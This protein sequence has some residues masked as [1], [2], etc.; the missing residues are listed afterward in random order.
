[1]ERDPMKLL[2][3]SVDN[4]GSYDYFEI[5]FNNCGL[6]LLHGKT[7]SGKS[8]IPDVPCWILYGKTAKDGA[9]DDVRSWT[10][11]NESTKGTISVELTNGETINVTRIRGKANDND[12]FWFESGEAE[13]TPCRGKDV[14]E[15]QK[16]LEKRIG[17]SFETY[18]AGS[19]YHEFTPVGL[20]FS[21]SA[22]QR[23]QVFEGLASMVTATALAEK[24]SLGKK[25][26]KASIQ[27]LQS[28]H[29]KLEG[30]IKHIAENIKI[31]EEKAKT[32]EKDK[33]EKIEIL[34]NK[35]QEWLKRHSQ[36][37]DEMLN[38]LDNLNKEIVL[39]DHYDGQLI[40]LQDR[41][42]NIKQQKCP[43]CNGP[44]ASKD[45]DLFKE[46]LRA[47]EDLKRNNLQKL[48]EFTVLFETVKKEQATQSPFLGQLQQIESE[49][50][51]YDDMAE[52]AVG[53]IQGAILKQEKV[54]IELDTA[55]HKHTSLDT[56]Y[57]LS[58]EL[59]GALLAKVVKEIESS[60]NNTLETYFDAELRV[61]FSIEGADNLDVGITKNGH[62]CN[63]KQLSKG[64]RQMLKLAFVTSVMAASAN[65]AGV[66][67]S[68]LFFDESLDGL[69][70]NL[71]IKAF[72][73][74]EKLSVNHESIFLI[75]HAPEFQ[76]LFAN[77]YHV[78]MEGDYS[79]VEHES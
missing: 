18:I 34:E 19:Y 54:E 66:H 68:T 33:K 24:S 65:Q 51:Q 61:A 22:K 29:D 63:Y 56:L 35:D 37:L 12:L 30:T 46:R 32:F 3:C 25:G 23:R 43:A 13:S 64:Q 58:Y 38:E 57:E 36:Y 6:T 62:Y 55:R 44:K 28:E 2:S 8:T 50:N 7:G 74:F 15:T 73:L 14:T 47:A 52:K 78:T 17:I 20:F 40:E 5:D 10:I 4:F 70:V 69:D 67:F 75:D 59:R 77:K 39:K 45:L 72:A 41:I 48:S 16:L 1:M 9:V 60:T 71:K 21:A 11:D 26:L 42:H 53:D 27:Y 49:Q 76:Q 79:Q 31:F